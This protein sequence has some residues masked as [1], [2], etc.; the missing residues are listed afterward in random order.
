MEV[1][2]FITIKL[3]VATIKIQ[4][5][6]YLMINYR[7]VGRLFGFQEYDAPVLEHE[8]LYTRKAGEEITQQMYNFI[9]KAGRPVAL[10]PELTPSLAR[11]LLKLGSQ[12]VFPVKWFSIPQCW[13]Y[14][15][16]CKGFV[17][18][19]RFESGSNKR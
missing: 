13:R 2:L 17:R 7:E 10:R 19:L 3:F 1:F 5:G 16:V 12:V 6:M 15:L 14:F 11:I 9:D 18:Y 4:I 8:E